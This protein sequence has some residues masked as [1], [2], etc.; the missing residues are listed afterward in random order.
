MNKKDLQLLIN[1]F[2]NFSKDKK[3]KN[4]NNIFID[5]KIKKYIKVN[6]KI[7]LNHFYNN[8]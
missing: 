5:K 1:D 8:K 2:S 4:N 3:D 7:Y 6:N